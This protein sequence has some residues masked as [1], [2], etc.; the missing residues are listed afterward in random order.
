[1]SVVELPA[2]PGPRSVEWEVVDFGG[3]LRGGLGGSSQRVNRLGNRW[4]VTVA[5]PP[6]DPAQGRLW[7]TRLSRALRNGASWRIRQVGTPP[8]SPGTVLVNGAGQA[9]AAIALDGFLPGYALRDGQWL[10]ILTGGQRYLYQCAAAVMANASGQATVQIEPP[11]R[12]VP[13]DNDP[14]E[15]GRPVIE[16]LLD[17]PPGLVLDERRLAAGFSFT[18]EETR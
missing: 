1:M 13:A 12:V 14:V 2:S 7:F 15:I 18:I 11:L 16:G 10:S 4:R 3:T 5:M 6:M 8:G 17:V 9:G